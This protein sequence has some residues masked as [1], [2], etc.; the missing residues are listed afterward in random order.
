MSETQ[1]KR[2]KKTKRAV[3]DA[4]ISLL[5]DKPIGQITVK[6]LSDAAHINRKTFYAHYAKVE[7]VIAELEDELTEN[8]AYYLHT[9]VMEGENPDPQYFIRFVNLV[10]NSNPAFFENVVSARNYAYLAQKIKRVFKKE[11]IAYFSDRIPNTLYLSYMT[12]Y[13]LGG[14]SALYVEWIMSGKQV[15]FEEVNRILMR[16][17][18]N[19]AQAIAAAKETDTPAQA[20][21]TPQNPPFKNLS[22]L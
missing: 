3:R 21:D 22:E 7:D 6:E 20:P 9:A 8:V 10:Y 16:L 11:L 13:F 17:S 4:V 1:D 18:S 12:E 2:V 14:M 19:W 5:R 15:P